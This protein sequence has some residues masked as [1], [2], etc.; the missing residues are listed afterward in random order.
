M[1]ALINDTHHGIRGDNQNFADYF[2][3]FLKEVFFP[4]IDEQGIKTIIHL[5]DILDRRKFVNYL[6]AENLKE[7]FIRPCKERKIDLHVIIGNHDTYYKN[8]NRHNCMRTLFEDEGY[9]IWYEG[10]EEIEIDGVKILIVPWINPENRD[11]TFDLIEKSQARIVMGHLELQGFEMYRGAFSDG[12][13]SHKIFNKF[14][15]VMSG[16]YHHKSTRNNIHYLGAPYEMTWADYKDP[17]GFHLFDPKTMELKHIHNPFR[18]FHKIYYND[19]VCVD[20]KNEILEQDFSHIE[21]AYVK[22]IVKE[23]INPYLYDLFIDKIEKYNPNNVQVVEDNFHLDIDDE[24]DIV[25]EA[26]D[27]MTI[28]K[29]YIG[30]C[31]VEKHSEL[32]S[33]FSELYSKSLEFVSSE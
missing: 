6:T 4:T 1:I 31:K 29:K 26:E 24:E 11:E 22:I 21:N 30:Q 17:R 32:E 15:I 3:K 7:H 13:I 27:T 8:T 18:M 20:K 10:P 19:N 12:G 2:H 9:P 28:I 5:G 14:D 33:L 25:N 16:H 23:R